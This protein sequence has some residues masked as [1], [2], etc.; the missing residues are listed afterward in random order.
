MK[1]TCKFSILVLLFIHLKCDVL[2][3]RILAAVS[4]PS[5]S[6]QKA[7]YRIWEQLTLRGH[8][9]VLITTDPMRNQ[10]LTNLTEVDLHGLYEVLRKDLS[11]TQL[12]LQ[13]HFTPFSYMDNIYTLCGVVVDYELQN[14]GVQKLV[15]DRNQHFDLVIGELLIPHAV[16]YSSRFDCPLIGIVSLDAFY[17]TQDFFGN[18]THPALYPYYD[19]GFVE[20]V[21]FTQRLKSVVLSVLFRYYLPYYLNPMI[22]EKVQKH[23]GLE[24]FNREKAARNVK[25]LFIN[26]NPVFLNTRPVVPGTVNIGGGNHIEEPRDLP[27]V[28]KSRIAY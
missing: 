15:N 28:S 23:F 16:A 2:G 4:M 20:A 22:N 9:V 26:V 21:S 11:L 6:H 5:F 12:N 1:R 13:E 3:A 24:W 7:Y 10:S 19:L 17:P 27:E 8:E 14:P 25:L 18:P